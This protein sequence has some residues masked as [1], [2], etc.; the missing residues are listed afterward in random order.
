MQKCDREC[1]PQ[2]TNVIDVTNGTGALTFSERS[3]LGTTNGGNYGVDHIELYDYSGKGHIKESS[4]IWDGLLLL[5][6]PFFRKSLIVKFHRCGRV[7]L[8][9]YIDEAIPIYFWIDCISVL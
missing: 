2:G 7:R 8:R 5:R 4:L 6:L 9:R 1:L 3:Q